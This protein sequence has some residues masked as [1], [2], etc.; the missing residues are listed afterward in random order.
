MNSCLNASLLTL[1]LIAALPASVIA[2]DW[3][4]RMRVIQIAPDVDTS[5]S[6][7]GLDVSNQWVPEID[8]TYFLSPNIGVELT[9]ATA[10]HTVNLSGASLGKL[11]HLPPTLTV[12]YHFD[13]TPSIKPYVCARVNYPRFYNVDLAPVFPSIATVSAAPCRQVSTS[14]SPKMS[15]STSTSSKSGSTPT[16]E[17]VVPNSPRSTST[18]WS[19]ASATAFDSDRTRSCPPRTL[20]A[21][22]P[23]RPRPG[24]ARRRSAA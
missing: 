6:L 7:A 8:F 15:T 10:R 21:A 20:A 1:A 3:M 18:R 4:V 22:A 2:D 12:Q 11:N 17:V 16:S 19:G 5:P 24:N 9:L 13:A 23:R 14:P